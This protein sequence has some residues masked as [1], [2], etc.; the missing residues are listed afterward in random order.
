MLNSITAK[1]FDATNSCGLWSCSK[2]FINHG[3]K[4][5]TRINCQMLIRLKTIQSS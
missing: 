2:I 5:E 3:A 4:C 1:Y